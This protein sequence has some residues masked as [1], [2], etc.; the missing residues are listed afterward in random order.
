[1]QLTICSNE[2]LASLCS[3]PAWAAPEAGWSCPSRECVP[4]ALGTLLAHPAV[5]FASTLGLLM[6]DRG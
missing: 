5:G 1:M 2:N 6:G 4:E 3:R